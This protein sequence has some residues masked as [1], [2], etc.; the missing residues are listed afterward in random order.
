[1]RDS[2]WFGRPVRY[3][4]SSHERSHIFGAIG[5]APRGEH[6]LQAVLVWEG[7]TGSFYLVDDRFRVVRTIPVLA[8]PGARFAALFAICDPTFTGGF[9]RL[10]D[11][12][13]LMALAA[14]GDAASDDPE[15]AQVVERLLKLDNLFPVPKEEFRDSPL[16]NCGV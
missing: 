8:Q 14:F 1:S 4:S 9:V 6:P 2:S 12:G 3:F 13:K 7:I 11:S 15:V 10:N 5:M 16:Y